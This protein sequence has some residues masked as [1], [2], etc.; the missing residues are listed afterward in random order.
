MDSEAR[1]LGQALTGE[2]LPLEGHLPTA[3]AAHGWDA[4]RLARL[5]D[6]RQR[7]G[8]P[9]PF[10]VPLDSIREV[11]FARFD[12]QLAAVRRELGLTGLVASAPAQRGLDADERRL[13]A[14]RPPHW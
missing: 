7:A 6:E 2:D 10:P 11:G 13:S 3:L 5:R 1:L 9:W 12:A 14:E 8:Q 4:E